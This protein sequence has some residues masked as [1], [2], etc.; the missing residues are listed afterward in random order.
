MTP[1]H[2]IQEFAATMVPE[3]TLGAVGLRALLVEGIQRWEAR[4][5]EESGD[6]RT[7]L[8]TSDD[9][10]D[11]I[12]DPN[13]LERFRRA[14]SLTPDWHEPDNQGVTAYVVGNHLD[15]AMGSTVDHNH[16]ELQVV[17]CREQ[18]YSE[19]QGHVFLPIA[20]VNLATL[21]SWATRAVAPEPAVE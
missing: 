20:V 21:L 9:Q 1:T 15:N 8:P 4:A 10:L 5:S 3:G 7:Y 14:Y 13:A 12:Q 19:E 18:N 6:L 2:D 17:L 16:G 11:R